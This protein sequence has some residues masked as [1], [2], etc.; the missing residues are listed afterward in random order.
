[1]SHDFSHVRRDMSIST[2]LDIA[3]SRNLHI[4]G[5]KEAFYSDLLKLR[6]TGN[7]CSVLKKV[8]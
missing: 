6:L 3:V 4:N 2:C 8:N 7:S 5:T 1:M